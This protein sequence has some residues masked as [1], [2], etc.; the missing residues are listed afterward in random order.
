MARY[1]IEC[2]KDCADRHPGCH[3]QC[4]KYQTEKAERDET[5]AEIRRENNAKHGLKAALFDSIH[6]TN[7]R[8][9]YRSKYRRS[10]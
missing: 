3:G 5:L 2:C 7:K 6:R 4:E 1:K 10:R 9:N 8:T